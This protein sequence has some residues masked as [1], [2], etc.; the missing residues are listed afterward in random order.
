MSAGPVHI[1]ASPRPTS[2]SAARWA[3]ACSATNGHC[4]QAESRNRRSCGRE[5]ASGWQSG[6]PRPGRAAS[7]AAART[8]DEP[9]CHCRAG[10][11]PR[12]IAQS[13]HASVRPIGEKPPDTFAVRACVARST[14]MLLPWG[15]GRCAARR[16][17]AL[18][19]TRSDQRW[20]DDTTFRRP[21]IRHSV[22]P[23]FYAGRPRQ[24]EPSVR[25]NLGA[26]QFGVGG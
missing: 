14:R 21:P 7:W 2:L 20:L 8:A 10:E 19:A 11:T 15:F 17:R 3:S 16:A 12:W 9:I 26:S 6:A 13:N 18:T 4:C 23:L 22:S 1:P 25:P 24:R 5:C